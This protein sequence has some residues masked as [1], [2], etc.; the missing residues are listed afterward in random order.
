MRHKYSEKH[1]YQLSIE[2]NSLATGTRQAIAPFSGSLAKLTNCCTLAKISSFSVACDTRHPGSQCIFT[3][4]RTKNTSYC[5]LLH[6]N[7]ACAFANLTSRYGGKQSIRILSGT[8]TKC[9]LDYFC[10]SLCRIKNLKSVVGHLGFVK[11][12]TPLFFLMLIMREVQII[13][14]FNLPFIE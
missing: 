1:Q 11:C 14:F 2:A 3:C 12:P 9:T 13:N 7:L 4:A 8:D 5:R 6:F 10:Q